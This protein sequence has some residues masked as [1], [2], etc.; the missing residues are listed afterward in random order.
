MVLLCHSLGA[1]AGVMAAVE[2]AR[3]EEE[4]KRGTGGAAAYPLAGIIM[5]GFGTRLI[6]TENKTEFRDGEQKKKEDN[7]F[8]EFSDEDEEDNKMI[9][10]AL[11]VK[12]AMMLPRGTCDEAV[13]GH[14][15][16][17]DVGFP[18]RERADALDTYLPR[19]RAGLAAGVRVPVL[20]GLAGRDCFWQG[21]E[22][23]LREIVAAF[24]ASPKAEGT[25]L[26]GAPH[27]IELSY[28]SQA[29]YARCFAFGLECAVWY[30]LNRYEV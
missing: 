15:G 9:H 28:W 12:D 19:F 17:L 30:H 1:P 11:D 14:T 29:W 6:E 2:F 3:E 5:S 20:V 24:A 26:R 18:A 21:D 27:C 13:Y 25:F 8:D 23:H 22:D 10:F 4:R 7:G 16:Q